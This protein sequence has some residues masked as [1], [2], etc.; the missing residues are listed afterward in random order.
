MGV[1]PAEDDVYD[2]LGKI[3]PLIY[4]PNSYHILDAIMIPFRN[5]SDENQTEDV[6]RQLKEA[7]IKYGA[8]AVWVNAKFNESNVYNET[9]NSAY[10]EGLYPPNHIVCLVG[11]DDTFPKEHFTI[12]PENDGAWII[13][14]SWGTN[15]GDEGYYYISYEDKSFSTNFAVGYIIDNDFLYDAVYQ[16]DVIDLVDYL[17]NMTIYSNVFL[18]ESNELLSA[19]GTYFNESNVDYTINIYVDDDLVYSQSGKSLWPGYRTIKLDKTI[20]LTN[21][22]T[23]AVEIESNS[24]PVLLGMYT[25][26]HFPKGV[27]F[28]KGTELED[29][30]VQGAIAC[31]KAYTILNS[32]VVNDLVKDFGDNKQFTVNVTVPNKQIVFEIDGKNYTVTSD[33]DGIARLD[34]GFIPGTYVITTYY[35]NLSIINRVIINNPSYL[36][37]IEQNQTIN[38]LKGKLNNAETE[39]KKAEDK[40]ND[41]Q[42]QLNNANNQI[43]TLKKQNSDANAKL[44][45][46]KAANKVK[47]S[48]NFKVTATL[49]KKVKGKYVYVSFNGKTY[50][51]KTNKKGVATITIKKSALKKI[52]GKKIKYQVIYGQKVINKSVKIKK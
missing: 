51:A 37:V 43:S 36:L 18:A 28:V 33:K 5:A 20:S 21:G 41:L 19:V 16:Y 13:K 17:P 38:E 12:Q 52:V 25:R 39:L 50:K 10:C 42:K 30:G 6:Y 8:L 9:Y 44:K 49:N 7:L 35:D 3:S 47:R 23:F 29:I 4:D 24:V 40:S 46:V 32:I 2:E 22:V 48:K 34:I 45:K 26:E 1:L 14:N 31:V 15:W 27:S 11:W